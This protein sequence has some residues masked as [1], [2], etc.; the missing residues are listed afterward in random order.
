MPILPVSGTSK[1]R[2]LLSIVQA[3]MGELG[4][5]TTTNVIGSSNSIASQML[6]LLTGF[7]DELADGTFFWQEL[8]R[9]YTFTLNGGTAYGLPADYV[10]LIPATSWDRTTRFQLNG[11][12][13]GNEWQYLKSW[14]VVAS[15]RYQFRM[16][17]DSFQ[18]Q[19]TPGPT[20]TDTF[21]FEYISS[22][23][24]YDVA[25]TTYLD[26]FTL[27]TQ[28]TVFPNRLM[29]SGLKMK[30]LRAKELPNTEATNEYNRAFEAAKGGDNGSPILDLT[31]QP[32][33]YLL[34]EN[35]I[36]PQGYGS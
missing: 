26:A 5:G 14:G 3:A 4:L 22:Q 19:P 7:G 9:E 18:I 28:I 29:I 17:R 35:N 30:Y 15:P 20:V 6:A 34:S 31:F 2:S 24:I 27:D 21:A 33:P 8:T 12:I 11:P 32:S 1:Q 36:P 25:N 10:R 13:S 16:L 23:W